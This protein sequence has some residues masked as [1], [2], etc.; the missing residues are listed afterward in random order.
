VDRKRWDCSHTHSLAQHRIPGA[1]A[2]SANQECV[3]ELRCYR[4][5]GLET[6]AG[7]R[8]AFQA[9][10]GTAGHVWRPESL[11]PESGCHRS[12][13]GRS[14]SL[15]RQNDATVPVADA[16]VASAT[17]PLFFRPTLLLGGMHVDGGL[18]SNLPAW[19]FDDEIS[20]SPE[21]V[22]I[23]G[24]RLREP[25]I[26][27]EAIYP[28]NFMQFLSRLIR[29]TIFGARQLE[30]RGLEDYYVI[31]LP[32]PIETLAFDQMQAKAT[33]LVIAGREGVKA[34]FNREI[35]PKD[36]NEMREVLSVLAN[37]F[38]QTVEKVAQE[39][40]GEPRCALLIARNDRFA[41]VAYSSH[42]GADDGL[43]IRMDSPGPAACF[44]RREP[45]TIIVGELNE[46]LTLHPS[47]KVEHAL[48]PTSVQTVCALPIFENAADWGKL[49]PATRAQPLGVLVL[50]AESNLLGVIGHQGL[51]DV[52]AGYAQIAGSTLT[53]KDEAL[54]VKSIRRERALDFSE[55]IQFGDEA[56][57]YLSSRKE[58]DLALDEDSQMLLD[59][60]YLK[61]RAFLKG[62]A[63]RG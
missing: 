29:A 10:C 17:F 54:P 48:R 28:T 32:S 16:V 26:A 4:R 33:D 62:K 46:S 25:A 9:W 23:I 34:Y 57:I 51:E 38:K 11:P 58:R 41:R 14:Q 21:R 50:D 55:L 27:S 18:L 24:F 63:G 52:L 30:S 39:W 12:D 7:W 35:G 43:S 36:P 49:D 45:V 42:R 20:T 60:I 22:P 3:A 19:V 1:E 13:I 15:R 31:D 6:L 53:G 5:R 47:H 37:F 2:P 44:S 40:R 56:G 61:Q 8:V 59:R